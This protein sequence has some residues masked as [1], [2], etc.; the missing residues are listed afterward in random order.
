MGFDDAMNLLAAGRGTHFDPAIIDVFGGIAR[1]L[2]D[3]YADRDD[4]GLRSDYAVILQRYY[5][6]DL[7]AF[8]S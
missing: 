6:T 4:E 3:T 5:K 7:T 2:F 1:P 8:M